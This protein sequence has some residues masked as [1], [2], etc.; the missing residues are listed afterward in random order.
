MRRKYGKPGAA[1]SRTSTRAQERTSLTWKPVY[2]LVRRVPKGRVI[3]LWSARSRHKIARAAHAR[4]ATPW[5]LVPRARVFPG[6]AWSAPADAFCWASREGSLQRRLLESEGIE[7]RGQRL[8]L[9]GREWHSAQGA[10]APQ[11]GHPPRAWPFATICA[12]SGAD[13]CTDPALRSPPLPNVLYDVGL[14]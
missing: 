7:F 11:P 6:I 1:H 8:E 9:E 4:Q 3:I 13:P 2:R 10:K 12:D 5:P 14:P